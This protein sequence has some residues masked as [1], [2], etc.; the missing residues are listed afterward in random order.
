MLEEF[1]WVNWAIMFLTVFSDYF[2]LLY[3]SVPGYLGYTYGGTVL[4]FIW[5][6]SQQNFEQEQVPEQPQSTSNKKQKI[7]YVRA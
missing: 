7:R 2:W 1:L 6:K 5:P 4:G 3:L